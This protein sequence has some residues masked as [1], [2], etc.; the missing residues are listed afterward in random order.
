MIDKDKIRSFVE[1]TLFWEL[2]VEIEKQFDCELDS[3]SP[4]WRELENQVID[5]LADIEVLPEEEIQDND[6]L[7]KADS[8]S[9]QGRGR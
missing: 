4:E 8:L 3:D 5:T 2:L 7:N 9:D 1:E 6:I